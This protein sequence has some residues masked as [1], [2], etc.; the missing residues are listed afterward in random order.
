VSPALHSRLA[1]W[2]SSS[3]GG[4]LG[5]VNPAENTYKKGVDGGLEAIEKAKKAQQLVEQEN[6]RL[7]VQQKQLE[8]ED[9]P[10]QR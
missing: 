8:A 4:G 7:Q 1:C 3:A 5:C 2:L 10:P 6:R 9:P